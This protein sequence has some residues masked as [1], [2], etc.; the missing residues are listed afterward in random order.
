MEKPYDLRVV[1][2]GPRFTVGF[3][4]VGSGRPP[5]QENAEPMMVESMTHAH[6]C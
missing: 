1:P 6:A 3:R 2:F 4:T 5:G